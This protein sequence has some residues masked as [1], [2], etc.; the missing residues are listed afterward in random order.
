MFQIADEAELQEN[1][2]ELVWNDVLVVNQFG[3]SSSDQAVGT[4]DG[5][6]RN[7]KVWVFLDDD[8]LSRAWCLAETGQYTNP[9]SGCEVIVY[10]KAE[11][12]PGTD[13]FGDMIAGVKEDVPLIQKYILGK[14]KY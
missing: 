14:Y 3:I 7:C 2:S 5:I 10:G 4:T 9:E 13:F 1:I 6:Y 8:Y 11:M 12:K